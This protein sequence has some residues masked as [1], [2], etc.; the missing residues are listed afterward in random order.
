[1]P[2]G[3]TSGEAPAVEAREYIDI[4]F[5]GPPSAPGR[6]VEVEAPAGIR[7]SAGEWF[8][9]DPYWRLRIQPEVFGGRPGP[10]WSAGP[11]VTSVGDP[12]WVTEEHVDA[13]ARIAGNLTA[14]N[15]R[16]RAA[17][18]PFA[19]RGAELALKRGPALDLSG[20]HPARIRDLVRADGAMRDA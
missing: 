19:D 7:I 9:D 8:R 12:A 5:D 16:L 1:M 3:Y 15:D 20:A 17:L 10:S 2:D 4:V 13:L 11:A 18:K 6:F 14:E